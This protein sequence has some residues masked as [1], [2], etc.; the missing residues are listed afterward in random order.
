MN[1]RVA[2]VFGLCV[3]VTTASTTASMTASAAET[4]PA[5]ARVVYRVTTTDPVFFVTID[6]GW[7][8]TK[9]AAAILDE[10]P[11]TFF[12]NDG[13]LHRAPRWWQARRQPVEVHTVTHPVL[14]RLSETKQRREICR[15]KTTV[16]QVTGTTPTLFRPPYGAFNDTTRVAAA[17]CGFDTL[18]LWDVSVNHGRVAGQLRPGS[19]V[20]LHFR[21]ELAADLDALLAAGKRKGLRPAA[22]AS[23][24]GR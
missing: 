3:A 15:N 17:A 11:A 20:L 5:K 8:R 21:P 22:L 4:A 2:A 23:Y 12:V 13:P 7:F 19:I 14:T 16:E 9:A 6:D 1:R 24:L 18:V 10:I